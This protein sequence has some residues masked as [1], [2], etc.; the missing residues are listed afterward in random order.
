MPSHVATRELAGWHL[1]YASA[2][3]AP[4]QTEREGK[5]HSARSAQLS[6]K[7]EDGRPQDVWSPRRKRKNESGAWFSETCAIAEVTILSKEHFK[8]WKFVKLGSL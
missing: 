4:G 8:A 2:P 3:G 7:G 5:H 1:S 6:P